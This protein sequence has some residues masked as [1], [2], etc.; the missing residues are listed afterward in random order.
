MFFLQAARGDERSGE[1][2][3][4]TVYV[5][6]VF[7]KRVRPEKRLYVYS[8]CIQDQSFCN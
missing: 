6:E 4:F 8:V 2:N 5:L 3:T 7:S 1:E